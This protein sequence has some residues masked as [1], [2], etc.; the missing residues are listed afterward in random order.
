MRDSY[1]HYL[2]I[3]VAT[4]APYEVSAYTL[5]EDTI[6]QGRYEYTNLL[7]QYSACMESGNWPLP[8]TG[9]EEVRLPEYAINYHMNEEIAA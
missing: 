1:E 7:A 2:F 3:V 9:I 6:E 4:D 5:D 8:D